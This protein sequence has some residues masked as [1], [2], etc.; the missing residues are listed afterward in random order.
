M[1]HGKTTGVAIKAEAEAAGALHR[2]VDCLHL[3]WIFLLV[4]VLLPVLH[5]VGSRN[6]TP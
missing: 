1:R 2:E 4:Q 3:E 5:V 6:R